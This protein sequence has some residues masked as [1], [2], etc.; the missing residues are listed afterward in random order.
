[1]ADAGIDHRPRRH[2]GRD[3]GQRDTEHGVRAGSPSSRDPPDAL[4][5]ASSRP[6]LLGQEVRRGAAPASKLS[7][8]A[9]TAAA[10]RARTACRSAT[11]ACATAHARIPRHSERAVAGVRTARP[12]IGV[13][14]ASANS[15]SR[16]SAAARA[17]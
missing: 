5:L 7:V 4:E 2:R 13:V 15:A 11:W 1:V 9:G 3:A 16:V 14:T 8:S 10:A 17:G 6:E 12:G